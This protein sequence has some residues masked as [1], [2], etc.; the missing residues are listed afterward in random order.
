MATTEVWRMSEFTSFD[1]TR[2]FYEC[3][4]LDETSDVGYD[5]ARPYA[6]TIPPVERTHS[7]AR[8]NS[9]ASSS[10][11]TATTISSTRRSRP[12]SP[13]PASSSADAY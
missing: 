1:G 4:G 7:T 12:N 3:V 10:A 8:S 9:S 2:L 11:R 13:C 6:R 5:S